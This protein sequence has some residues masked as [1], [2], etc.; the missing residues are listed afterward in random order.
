MLNVILTGMSPVLPWLM[1]WPWHELQFNQHE[2]LLCKG[3]Y[4]R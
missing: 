3:V 1:F 4:I 2:G